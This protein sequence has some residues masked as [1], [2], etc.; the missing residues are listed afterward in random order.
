VARHAH[1]SQVKIKVR[2]VGNNLILTIQDD[3]IGFDPEELRN[4][5]SFG[6]RNMEQRARQLSGQFLIRSEAGQGTCLIVQIPFRP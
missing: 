6:L 3:G 1:A 5:E 2:E 4:P